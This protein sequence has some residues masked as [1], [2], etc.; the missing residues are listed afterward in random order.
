MTP[1]VA[2]L[3][4]AHL[5]GGVAHAAPWCTA[6]DG[7]L[8]AQLWAD[9]KAA[10]RAAGEPVT[11]AMD[12]DNPPD[13]ELPLA[14][15]SAAGPDRWHWAATC[16]YPENRPADRPPDVHYWTG[17]PDHRVLEQLADRV[18]ASI[19]ERQGRYRTRRMPLLVTICTAV[20]WHAVGDPAAVAE[21]VQTIDAIGKKRS[22]GEGRVLRWDV[23]TNPALDSFT[24]GHLHPDSTLGRPTPANCLT[25]RPPAIDGGT[26]TA[27]LRPPY[28]HH[29]R[30]HQLRLPASPA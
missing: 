24:A 17:R 10:A 30:Q 16:G 29:A 26:G 9:R 25:G 12:N 3:V 28:M 7:L 2:M 19:S 4:R 21:I 1:A 8:A 11:A 15:C 22:Q 18:P 5:A 6:L 14:R 13:L 27:G 23:T 20:T